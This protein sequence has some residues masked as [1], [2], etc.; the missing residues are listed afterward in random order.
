MA[1]RTGWVQQDVRIASTSA[2]T[3]APRKYSGSLYSFKVFSDKAGASLR[4]F[5]FAEGDRAPLV[6]RVL[7]VGVTWLGS[8][9]LVHARMHTHG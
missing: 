3:F 2:P 8:S 5:G 4:L 9:D 7:T 1:G 6:L